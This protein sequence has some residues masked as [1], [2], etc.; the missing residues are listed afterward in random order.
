MEEI[1]MLV[2][3]VEQLIERGDQNELADYLNEL[4]ISDVEE[5]IDELPEH[6]PLFLE[7]LSLRRAVNVFRILV[8]PTQERIF[9]KLSATKIR[10]LL[11]EMPPDDRTSFFSELTGDVVKRLIILL[12]PEERKEALSLL[13]YPEDSVGRLMTPDYITVREHWSMSRVLDHIRRYG[14]ASETIDVLYV[15]DADGKLIDDVRIKDVLLGDP[16]KRISDLIDNR[17]I[18]LQANDPQEEA[19]TIFRMNNRVALPVVDDKDIM[20]GIV[21]IDDILWVANEEY[22][23]DMQR[24]GGT[25]ALDEPYLDVSVIHLVKKRAGWLIVL[26]LGQLLTFNVL[27]HYE[28]QLST[29]LVLLMP[30]IM[31]SG[32]NSGS[33][34][35]TLIIQAMAMGEVTLRDWWLVMRREIIS[36]LLL[37]IILGAL[38]FFRIAFEEVFLTAYGDAW[39][40]YGLAIGASLVGVVLW[41]SLVGSMLP[42]ILRRCGA[43][44]ASSS[45][46]FVAT[47]VDVTGLVIYFSFASL[48][49]RDVLF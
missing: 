47:I 42:F 49:L 35:S 39:Y 24:I 41:G 6:G 45:A 44:P 27:K 8:F 12:T 29:I 16:E 9:K 14:S 21:T 22:S 13:G 2:A 10:E 37:G 31:S 4:N 3:Q 15:I 25:E 43:D 19:V 5:L 36:G 46:P 1:A 30:V 48:I 18:S 32:G 26:F 40:L 17:L 7:T 23:E 34:A 11:N 33:Q 20:L 38:G 28:S